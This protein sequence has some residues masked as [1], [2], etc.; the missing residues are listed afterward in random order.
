MSDYTPTTEEVRKAYL[1]L[2][3]GI[4]WYEGKAEAIDAQFDRWLA[5]VKAD[6]YDKAIKA[7]FIGPAELLEVKAQAW[8]EGVA[9]RNRYD[10]PENPYREGETE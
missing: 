2:R 8:A 3:G 7:L 4:T 5:G 9:D 1:S 10:Y 6:A